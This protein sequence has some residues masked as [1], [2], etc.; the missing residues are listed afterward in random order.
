MKQSWG[1]RIIATLEII[2]FLPM[3]G[4]QIEHDFTSRLLSYK[5]KK[6]I[7]KD[8]IHSMNRLEICFRFFIE[9]KRLG[10]PNH[11]CLKINILRFRNGDF[12]FRNEYFIPKPQNPHSEICNPKSEMY[13]TF[14]TY[15]N[16][17]ERL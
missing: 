6:N 2:G 9:N 16:T 7:V 5:V 17:L 4:I 14:D 12:G 1:D 11:K 15:D 8:S 3:E 10:F 13:V